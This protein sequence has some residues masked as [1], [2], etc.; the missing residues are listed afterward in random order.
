M[1][2][3]NDAMQARIEALERQLAQLTGRAPQQQAIPENERADYIEHGSER[4]VAFLGLRK[5]T[6]AEAAQAE[7]REAANEIGLV[8][9]GYVLQDITAFGV[10]AEAAMLKAILMQKVH[11]LAPMPTPQ[12][13]D[14]LAPNYAP[15]LWVPS[16]IPVSGVVGSG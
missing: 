1:A 12:S 7:K 10:T 3:E 16:G 6:E 4:H 9:E 8:Y 11:Q 15:R 13:D 14:P 2:K 5:A